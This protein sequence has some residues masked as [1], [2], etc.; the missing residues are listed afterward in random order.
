VTNGLNLVALGVAHVGTVV[1]GVVVGPPPGFTVT[2]SA[3]LER[4]RV[5][6]I[7]GRTR[8]SQVCDVPAVTGRVI[9]SVEGFLRMNVF[10]PVKVPYAAKPSNLKSSLMPSVPS[11]R[12]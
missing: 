10:G 3:H 6:R 1:A 2:G 9:V 4:H 8:R 7:D 5:E 12:S 11:T